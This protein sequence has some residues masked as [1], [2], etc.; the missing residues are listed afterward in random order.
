MPELQRESIHFPPE[1][2]KLALLGKSRGTVA[3]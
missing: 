3:A 2:G 1:M